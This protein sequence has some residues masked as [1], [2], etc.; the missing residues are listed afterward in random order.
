MKNMKIGRKLFI[1]FAVPIALMIVIAI[2]VVVMNLSTVRS[3]TTIGEQTDLWNHANV[4]QTNFLETRIQ[5]N[6]LTFQNTDDILNKAKGY[7]SAAQTEAKAAVDYV[8]ATPDVA[9]FAD[10]A[11]SAETGVNDYAAELDAMATALDARDAAAAK[12]T[13]TGAMISDNTSDMLYDQIETMVGEYSSVAANPATANSTATTREAIM[14]Q[15]NDVYT[16]VDE[17]R[18][19]IREQITMYD[20][21]GAQEAL[22]MVQQAI[23]SVNT[24]MGMLVDQ[25]NRDSAQAVLDNF[26]AYSTAFNEYVGYAEQAAT[27]KT[28][29]AN[30]GGETG[31]A[32]ATLADQNTAVNGNV[33]VA[34]ETAYIALFVI[35]AIVVIALLATIFMA[36]TI[37]KSITV[38]INYV[39]TILTAIGG[40]GR[41]NFSEEE[42]AEQRKYA[43]GSDETAECSQNLGV[44]ANALNGVA[45]LLTQIAGGDLTMSHQALSEEDMISASIVKM[46]DNLNFMFG[47]IAN[48]SD[49]VSVGAAQIS[50]ASQSLASGSTEQAAT[51][52]E[53][54]ASIQDVAEKTRENA[55][56]ANNAAE[57][58]NSI[59]DNAEKGSEQMSEMTKAVTE[60]NQASQDISKVIKVI[61]DIAFQTNILALNAAV[62][63]A[64]AGE[65]GKGFAVVADEV[66]NLASKSAAAAKETGTLIENSMRKA[67]LGSTI[68]AQ[69]ANSLADIVEG[70]N[71]SSDLIA[72][73]ASSSEEQNIAIGQ[74][75]DGIVQVSE[76][77][78]KNS[79][80]AEECAASAEELNAQSVV[81][82]GNIAKFRLKKV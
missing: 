77:V 21:A 56:R 2:L 22:A 24:Y 50:D 40:R 70:I 47:E 39:T 8:A 81:L 5:A 59:K 32:L 14:R 80:T 18:I 74:I 45:G 3:I 9:S 76:V 49:Q 34:T 63:A 7:I 65:A 6:I 68:A 64:R 52:E 27:I 61:D 53:L 20:A 38:P 13:E 57:L 58:S 23:D 30:I 41:T 71:R 33:E 78:Q 17:A 43:A 60:I 66:R 35:A 44:V 73:I 75:N 46:I 25:T 48:A 37:T 72:E 19:L 36:V 10:A 26:D 28:N 29:F 67:E 31:T 11:K 69:T 54:S 15:M 62:E 1:G 16:Y 4:S 55:S 51:V 82:K 79:A 12:V 42:W